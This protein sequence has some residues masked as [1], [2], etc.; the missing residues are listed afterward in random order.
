M[1]YRCHM[2]QYVIM[3]LMLCRFK[4]KKRKWKNENS[5]ADHIPSDSKHSLFILMPKLEY[6]I[7][8]YNHIYLTPFFEIPL[9]GK[10]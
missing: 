1:T 5:S 9:L 2:G 7:L 3:C 6:I 8:I 4:K 10:R